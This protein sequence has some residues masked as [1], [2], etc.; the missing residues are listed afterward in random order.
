MV[1]VILF[2]QKKYVLGTVRSHSHMTILE[3]LEKLKC[4]YFA[5]E[6][7]IQL[8]AEHTKSICL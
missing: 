8:D 3:Y 7:P 5:K 4:W 1:I 2:W 6:W